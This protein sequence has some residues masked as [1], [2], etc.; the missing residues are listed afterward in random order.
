MVHKGFPKL[1]EYYAKYKDRLEIIGID[2]NDKT[3]AW[4]TAVKKHQI[5]WLQVQS[6]DAKTEVAYAVKGYPYKVIIAPD[7]KVLKTF[8]GEKDDFY[9]YLDEIMSEK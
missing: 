1:K 9:N 8:L 5:P 3:E 7:G 2:C 4:K 6:E